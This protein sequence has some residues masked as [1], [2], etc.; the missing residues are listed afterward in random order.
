MLAS[1]TEP[2]KRGKYPLLEP[3]MKPSIGRNYRVLCA[4]RKIHHS[5]NSVEVKMYPLIGHPHRDP[6]LGGE[7]LHYH[8]DWRFLSEAV[9]TSLY[10]DEY[11]YAPRRVP[12]VFDMKPED[13]Y[14]MRNL[15]CQREMPQFG[16]IWEERW[17]TFEKNFRCKKLVNGYICPHRGTDLRPF[18]NE[19]GIAVCPGHGLMW[20]LKT[21]ES[22]PHHNPSG[23]PELRA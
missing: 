20:N 4:L 14:V 10:L 13:K 21:G 15:R 2:A 9:F 6:E 16:P 22:L 18:A 17:M 8:I 3:G 7:F 23:P 5:K 11:G 19:E 12:Y 1:P